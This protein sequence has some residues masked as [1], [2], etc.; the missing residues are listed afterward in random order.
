MGIL[1]VKV[2]ASVSVEGV[3]SYA[4]YSHALVGSEVGFL[5]VIP[6]KIVG[7]VLRLIWVAGRSLIY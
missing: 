5:H 3:G 1:A 2:K 6:I 7:D 4:M